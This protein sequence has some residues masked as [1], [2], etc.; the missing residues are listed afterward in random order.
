V[1]AMASGLPVVCLDLGGPPILAGGGGAVAPADTRVTAERIA[2]RVLEAT[3]ADAESTRERASEF[4]LERRLARLE[5]LVQG[6]RRQAA[7]S[8]CTGAE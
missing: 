4:L 5:H 3:E 7:F 2:Q 6:R 1:E 8:T